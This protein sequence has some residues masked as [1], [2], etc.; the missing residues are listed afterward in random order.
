[1]INEISL[2]FVFGLLALFALGA[3]VFALFRRSERSAG[4][5][6]QFL[7]LQQ[8]MQK[9]VEFSLARMREELA[10]SLSDSSSQLRAEVQSLSQQLNERMRETSSTLQGTQTSVGQRL[11]SAARVIGELQNRLGSLDESSKRILD[12]GQGLRELKDIL[13]SPKLR[14]NMGEFFLED[15]LTQILPQG[16]FEMQ[17]AFPSGE[18]V[19]AV[20]RMGE[21]LVCVDSKFPIESFRRLI[22]VPAEQVDLR[23][24]EAKS[25]QTVIRKHAESIAKKYIRPQDGTLE[26]AFM[27]I[28]AENIYYETIIRDDLMDG[29]GSLYS[30]LLQKRVIPV[31]PNSLYAYLQVILLGL[32]GLKIQES[33]KGI[34]AGLGQARGDLSRLQED[35]AI[36]GKHLKN[37][38]NA[39]EGVGKRFERFHERFERVTQL[40]GKSDS[41]AGLSEPIS[42]N[43]ELPL[44]GELNL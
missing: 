2:W 29:E 5:A 39:Y 21:S 40:D 35:F 24:R 17:F 38:N 27:Y 4:E 23:Q 25:F 41:T 34:L 1:M 26:F 7:L 13:Q 32:R 14:G 9:Q 37:A 28:P 6:G 11:D 44:H 18:T 20:I 22:E 33:A 30:A 42:K 10:R 12:V 8:E 31:S 43:A 19:D 36:L 15:A 3:L 16:T